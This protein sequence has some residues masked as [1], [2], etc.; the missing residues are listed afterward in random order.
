MAGGVSLGQLTDQLAEI[1]TKKADVS[2]AIEQNNKDAN[3]I[4][5]Q[6]TQTTSDE[7]QQ[8]Q[9]YQIV[10][11]TEKRDVAQAEQN[12]Q[13]TLNDLTAKRQ[14]LKKP[15]KA[16]YDAVEGGKI[17]G[18]T[19]DQAKAEFDRA[20]AVLDDEFK[21]ENNR[22]EQELKA[23]KDKAKQDRD[24]AQAKIE[25]CQT[26]LKELSKDKEANKAEI[27]KLLQEEQKALDAQLEA[28]KKIKDAKQAEKDEKARLKDEKSGG[29]DGNV[30]T[31]KKAERADRKND[32]KVLKAAKKEIKGMEGVTDI[33]VNKKTGTITYTG[34][35]GNKHTTTVSGSA[36]GDA[37]PQYTLADTTDGGLETHVFDM[38]FSD[39][40][41]KIK[42]GKKG[43][44]TGSIKTDDA[45]T[46]TVTS[47]NHDGTTTTN[48]SGNGTT[49][50]TITGNGHNESATVNTR[51]GSTTTNINGNE[52]TT[53]DITRG[54]DGVRIQT[55]TKGGTTTSVTTKG[56]E[57][58]TTEKDGNGNIVKQTIQNGN[59]TT[60]ITYDGDKKVQT[61]KITTDDNGK[62]VSAV[63]S[64]L[65]AN[66]NATRT[67]TTNIDKDGNRTGS[68]TVG[69]YKQD[70]TFNGAEGNDGY[71]TT[72]VKF[73]ETIDAVLQRMGYDKNNPDYSTI[74]A[75]FIKNNDVKTKNGKQYF[76][77]G[78]EVKV[79]VSVDKYTPTKSSQEV[80]NGKVEEGKWKSWHDA[81]VA[82]AEAARK[83]AEAARAAAN[84]GTSNNG[85]K[86]LDEEMTSRGYTKVNDRQ[87]LQGVYMKNGKYYMPAINHGGGFSQAVEI[88]TN[89]AFNRGV[90]ANTGFNTGLNTGF[91][92][93]LNGGNRPHVTGGT[94]KYFALPEGC[95]LGEGMADKGYLYDSSTSTYYKISNPS[96]HYRATQ[97]LNNVTVTEISSEEYQRLKNQPQFRQGR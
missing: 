25:E 54:D 84:Q 89:D 65:D 58:T 75:E 82:K 21:A 78:Q 60:K 44:E 45:G 29:I 14:G 35:D 81:Q 27:E 61:T 19:Y 20:S 62:P 10:S 71:T 93:G 41:G 47:I 9:M 38:D 23:I 64:D 12:H 4:Q 24:E 55:V 49:T 34:A 33:E 87:G 94:D 5:Q 42:K 6:V 86:T 2:Q 67:V 85:R 46:R 22:Y 52:V 95:R 72:N 37:G 17:D 18:K 48:V 79:P 77:A 26:K 90:R 28:E 32:K 59:T 13:T 31:D 96:K 51:N 83:A 88:S 40:G 73:G 92:T 11:D 56:E 3:D 30:Y 53:S 74:K 50:A 7:E 70:V 36:I 76:L 8:E 43:A 15:E 91:N 57:V 66:G 69:G 16:D 80:V 63:V 1:K 97:L 39:A 68:I